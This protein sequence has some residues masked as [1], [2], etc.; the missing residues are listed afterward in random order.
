MT[1]TAVLLAASQAWPRPTPPPP[2]WPVYDGTWPTPW[3]IWDYIQRAATLRGLVVSDVRIVVDGE[4]GTE[5]PVKPNTAGEPAWGPFQLHVVAEDFRPGFE[6]DR[7]IALAEP[8]RGYVGD[9]FKY[10]TGIHPSE[11]RGWK[12]A[13]DFALDYAIRAGNW[14]AWYGARN[15]PGGRFTPVV[16]TVK[17]FSDEALAYSAPA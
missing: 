17:G 11:V 8:W 12:L 6:E 10:A 13:V 5:S 14:S 16:G 3:E 7:A 15:L 2:I 1:R 4:G 9:Q